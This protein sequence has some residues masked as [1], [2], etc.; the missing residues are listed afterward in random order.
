M[1]NIAIKKAS[2]NQETLVPRLRLNEKIKVKYNTNG[3][4]KNCFLFVNSDN[5]T[6]RE[7]ISFNTDGFIGFAGWA[8]DTN[9]KPM[10]EAFVDWCDYMAGMNK[11]AVGC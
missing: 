3:T 4:I 1:L 2:K 8:D 11:E 5:F 10:I 9:V 6:R 7:C